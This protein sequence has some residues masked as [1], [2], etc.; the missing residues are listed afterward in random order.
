MNSWNSK[1]SEWTPIVQSGLT[2]PFLARA[3]CSARSQG[4]DVAVFRNAE[5]E[6]FA[7]LD[8]CPH[9]GGPL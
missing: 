8:R 3:E 2:F 9:K 6:V 7:L 4:L 5:D 1:M